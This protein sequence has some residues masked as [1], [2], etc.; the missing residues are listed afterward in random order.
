MCATSLLTWL[1]H[2]TF[3]LSSPICHLFLSPVL[4]PDLSPIPVPCFCIR[5]FHVQSCVTLTRVIWCAW[6]W[7]LPSSL[8]IYWATAP[9]L[10]DELSPQLSPP[11]LVSSVSC[12]YASVIFMI[13]YILFWKLFLTCFVP[14]LLDYHAACNVPRKYLRTTMVDL[15]INSYRKH[16]VR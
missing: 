6:Q 12:S 4:S 5:L 14:H 13:H 11:V 2:L 7:A 16:V 8:Q 10:Q 15:S 3:P 9:T 1:C